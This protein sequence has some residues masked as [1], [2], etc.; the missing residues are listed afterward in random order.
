M[1]WRD[2][3]HRLDDV[4]DDALDAVVRWHAPYDYSVRIA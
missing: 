3:E 1:A 2:V 4:H